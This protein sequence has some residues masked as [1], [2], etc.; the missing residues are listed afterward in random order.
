MEMN[1]L[2]LGFIEKAMFS[3]RSLYKSYGYSQYQMNK[4]EEYDLYAK[5]KDFL[6]SENVIT[7]TDTDGKLMALKTDVTLSIVKNDSDKGNA[8]R[9]LYYNENVYRVSKGS[10]GFREILQV[11]LE[12][13]GNIDDYC[14]SEVV[15]LAAESLRCIS[16]DS[17][18]SI[19]HLGLL[20]AFLDAIGM[21]Q[22]SKDTA[23]LFI[24][25]KNLHELA[26]L[27]RQ[28]CVSEENSN[29][30]R[31]LIAISGSPAEVLPK[32]QELIGCVMDPAAANCLL[33]VLP[34]F[35]E[36]I[37][38]MLRIDFSVVDDI[39]YYNGIV[40]KGFIHGIPG[41]V[42]SGGQYDK[43][44]K[45][46]RKSAGAIGFAVYMDMLEYLDSEIP[47]YDVDTV[48]LYESGT[49]ISQIRAAIKKLPTHSS[50]LV[51]TQVPDHIQYRQLL[52]LCN[53]EVVILEDNA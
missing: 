28:C 22:E 17:I 18:L 12:C 10:H 13:L 15:M 48:F 40:L 30:L 44:M 14:I 36:T 9:K 37:G 5:N 23:L 4:F 7:F 26:Q 46:M 2:P 53:G 25:E 41:S 33:R 39:H 50:I 24:G 38:N 20:S 42:L 49:P 29:L 47:A 45:K 32:I 19:S 6:I 35:E 1:H 52:K 8:L 27:C 3:L 16:D 11:G 43:L 31:Q 51:Q 34:T 21:P